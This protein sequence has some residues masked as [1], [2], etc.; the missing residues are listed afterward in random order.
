MIKRCIV[1]Q[2]PTNK[3]HVDENKKCWHNQDI[4]FSTWK[5]SNISAYDTNDFVLYNTIPNV[6]GP[7]NWNL[8]RIST[9]NGILK[10]KELGYTRV[11]KWRSDFKTNNGK[12][13]LELFDKNKLNFYAYMHHRGG[14]ITDFF[15]EGD[16]N[17]MFNI[18]NTDEEGD[19]PER[20]LT[21]RIIELGLKD[22]C[23]FICKDLTDN[24]NIYWHK[25]SYW[26]TDNVDK[27]GYAN[28][29]N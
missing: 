14:Y 23:N 9:L 5:G 19:F 18:F 12:D 26:F 8:Q 1:I 24:V 27:T 2:G 3:F 21:N 6:K 25:L 28:Y 20:I 29:I 16:I 17:D 13:L 22:K 15:M 7:K 4:I 11:L 10:A